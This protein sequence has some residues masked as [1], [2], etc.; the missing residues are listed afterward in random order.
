MP[1]LTVLQQNK[2]KLFGRIIP[3]GIHLCSQPII[4]S[5]AAQTRNFIIEKTAPVFNKKGYAGT[6]LTDITEATGL[7]KGSIYGNFANKDE[8]ALAVFDYN[9]QKIGSII[10]A[11]SAKHKSIKAQLLV[12]TNVYANLFRFPVTAGGCP[13][14]NTAIEADDTHPQ[15]KEKVKAAVISWKNKLVKMIEKGIENKE[16]RKGI[17]AEQTALSFIATLEGGIMVAG[18]TGKQGDMKLI[19]QFVEKMIDDLE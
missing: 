10:R 3:I 9:L 15:L 13:I 7:T 8:V 12:Y 14:L 18:L 5:K 4:M 17:N 6:S 16:F 19:T 2:P 1:T 11:K